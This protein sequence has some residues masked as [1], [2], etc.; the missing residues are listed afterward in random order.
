MISISFDKIIQYQWH[1][2]IF[3]C[4]FMKFSEEQN[5]LDNT[6]DIQIDLLRRHLSK[7]WHGMCV[8]LGNAEKLE[9][10]V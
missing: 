8:K 4:D 2:K 3:L 10:I 7:V 5:G 1:G 6:L 9:E